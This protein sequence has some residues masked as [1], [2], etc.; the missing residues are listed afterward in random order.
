MD[1]NNGKARISLDDP[2]KAPVIPTNH[3]T[4]ASED[5]YEL[6]K[7]RYAG[8]LSNLIDGVNDHGA[9]VAHDAAV[10]DPMGKR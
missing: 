10:P 6:L 2:S 9:A 3:G 5:S 1:E 7:Q 4:G 8:I